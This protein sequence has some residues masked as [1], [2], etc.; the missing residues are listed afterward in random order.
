VS[1]A[2]RLGAVEYLN[3][4]PLVYG[5]DVAGEIE[6][7]AISVRF[8]VPSVCADRLARGEID[9]GLI[10]TIAYLDRPADRAVPGVAIASEG[11]VASVA[12]FTR[13]LMREVRSVALDTSSRTSVVLAR[14]LCAR[15]FEI[16]PSYVPHAPDLEAMLAS[17]DAAV[18]IGDPALFVDHRALS[19][20]KIDMGQSWSDLTGLPFVWAFWAGRA[21]AADAAV[22]RRLQAARDA[23]VAASD[24]IADAYCAGDLE[25]QALA[26]RYLRENIRYD[27]P[28]RSLEGLRAY[29]R[30]ARA[31]GLTSV[32]PDIA[33][34]RKFPGDVLAAHL[35]R[36]HD[37]LRFHVSIGLVTISSNAGRK[38][39][40]Y[41]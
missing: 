25:R 39:L 24:E 11:E 7:P 35:F 14:I 4:R 23:G 2:V 22:V 10:P 6:E 34:R 33:H 9:L 16:A 28:Q 32:E 18:L 27:L 38:V 3:A 29:Y 20:D 26:R 36:G 15:Q 19:A 17:C 41:R 13:R 31:L 21:N 40:N 5:L 37:R 30:E 8:D 1:R 12:L